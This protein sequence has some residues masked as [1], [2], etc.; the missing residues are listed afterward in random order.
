MPPSATAAAAPFRHLIGPRGDW[1]LGIFAATA[2]VLVHDADRYPP[3][4]QLP[5][6]I[7]AHLD[8]HHPTM[9]MAWHAA[10]NAVSAVTANTEPW[11]RTAWT[12]VVPS[13]PKLRPLS[14][15]STDSTTGAADPDHEAAAQWEAMLDALAKEDEK[16]VQEK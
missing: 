11:I 7:G 4:R 3:D 13:P 12:W 2:G 8:Q 16:S 5:A 9:A 6:M 15:T 1:A 10:G 14:P